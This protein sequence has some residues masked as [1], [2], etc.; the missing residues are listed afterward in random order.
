MM[1]SSGE[2]DILSGLLI[3][4]LLEEDLRLLESTKEAERLQLD[5]VL[6]VSA[7]AKG[8]IPKF[9]TSAP[10]ISG[11]DDE[12]VALE[13]LAEDARVSSD[14]AFA[15]RVQA[16]TIADM[17]YAQKVAA[18]EK[19]LMLDAEFA[20]R[21]QAVDDEGQDTDQ[22]KDAESL[23]GRDAVERIMASDLNEKGKGKTE[24]TD[25]NWD[26]VKKEEF[27]QN[28]G[29]SLEKR[30][31]IGDEVDPR[32]SKRLRFMSEDLNIKQEDMERFVE[33]AYATCGIC[34]DAFQPTYSPYTAS[35]TANSSSRL[36]FG[37][38]L[39]CPHQHAYCVGCLTSY[40]E[41]KLDP[42][43]KGSGN[44]GIIVFPIRCPECPITD[45]MD[46]IPDDI[47]ARV[48]G[49]EKMV[50]WDHQKLLN[51][52]P[53]LYCPNPKC[54]AIV[55]TPEDTDN[56]QAVCPSC[57][58]LLCVACRVA[59]HDDVS[60][61]Q[62][63]ALPPDERSPEDRLLHE[64]A[65]AKH[66]R[67]CPNCS[68]LV[69]LVSGCNHMTC[70]CGTHFCFKCG[71]LATTKG[72]CK[73]EPPCELWDE[74]MLLEERERERE[75]V[76]ILIPPAHPPPAYNPAPVPHIPQIDYQQINNPRQDSLDWMD[77]PNVVCSRHP[78]T[79]DMISNLVC[80]YCNVRLN[81][82]ADLRFHLSHDYERH[83]DTYAARFRGQARTSDEERLTE[84]SPLLCSHNH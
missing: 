82:L 5:Q 24:F 70:R 33:A 46:G 36:Q 4:Q 19:K 57:Q 67:R 30:R 10:G 45:F 64:L 20:R 38:R 61:E 26:S 31:D 44:S 29:Q 21:L 12:D 15:Q 81:S 47:A 55:Q 23:L 18:A 74:E 56:P 35:L 6:A 32:N 59:W 13:I 48:L 73:R 27:D 78:F 58:L 80:G 76:A 9:S 11:K 60:C 28:L 84:F 83:I 7:R 50:L 66:W 34:M 8:R 42:D 71:S 14:A 22:V 51:S 3:A 43:G 1:A 17:Q 2:D 37:L 75:R 62:Y 40:I 53:H 77:D 79:T 25:D 68:S 54:S 72:M 49:P 52:I 39:P 63:Q 41:S 65:K 69:E 16:S